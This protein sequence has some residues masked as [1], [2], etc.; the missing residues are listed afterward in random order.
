MVA[1]WRRT[2]VAAALTK[3]APMVWA[4]AHAPPGSMKTILAGTLRATRVA[5]CR[6]VTGVSCRWLGVL[7]IR[8]CWRV[9]VRV[10][11]LQFF[12]NFPP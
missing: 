3:H 6:A 7:Q 8:A 2:V 10:P 11:V 5:K 1:G 12:A 4:A 9:R